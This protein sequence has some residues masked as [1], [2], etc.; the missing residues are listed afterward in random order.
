ML[1]A[2]GY[3]KDNIRGLCGTYDGNKYDDLTT[4]KNCIVKDSKI[5]TA[6]YA[7]LHDNESLQVKETDHDIITVPCYKKTSRYVRMINNAKSVMEVL[8]S[9]SKN[10]HHRPKSRSSRKYFGRYSNTRG[11]G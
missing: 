3:Y 7:L 8:Q 2:A 10:E 4:P 5:F 6:S 1:Q 11:S 9:S